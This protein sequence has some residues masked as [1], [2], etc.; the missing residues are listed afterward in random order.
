LVKFEGVT[1]KLN[2]FMSRADEGSVTIVWAD[3][4]AKNAMHFKANETLVTLKFTAKTENSTVGLTL[5]SWSELND[6]D[7]TI[8]S[9][10]K[11]SAPAIQIGDIPSVFSLDQ[12]YPNPFNP[13]TSIKFGLLVQSPVTMEIYNILGVKVRTLLRGEVMSAGIHQMEWNGKDDAGSAV[14]S[15]V[16][17][18]RINAG[19]FQVTKKM[20]MLK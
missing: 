2:G 3:L 10:A 13:S 11:L 16:Y 20:M 7:G 17:L 18:Y 9:M 4:S 6:A 8:I 19:T 1:S 12:N 14:T 5:D 15:G